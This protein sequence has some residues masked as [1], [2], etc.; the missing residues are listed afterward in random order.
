MRDAVGDTAI[1]Q[2]FRLVRGMG[3]PDVASV[4]TGI[5]RDSRC[6]WRVPSERKGRA[7]RVVIRTTLSLLGQ[8]H[9]DST[10]AD[11]DL[12]SRCPYSVSTQSGS[13]VWNEP[14]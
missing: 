6:Q 13:T 5:E 8:Q 10:T 2:H 12:V 1:P 11:D 14:L 7:G 9:W 3:V 4:L